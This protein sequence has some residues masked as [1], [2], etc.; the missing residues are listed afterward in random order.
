M[1]IDKAI[2]VL[3]EFNTWRRGA[4]TEMLS[5]KE[6]GV[7]IDAIIKHYETK[8]KTKCFNELLSTS[9]PSGNL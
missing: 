3:K 2:E 7:A 8:T 4:E 6:I 1:K 5:P 9:K